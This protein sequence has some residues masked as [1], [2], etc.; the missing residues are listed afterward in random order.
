MPREGFSSQLYKAQSLKHSCHMQRTPAAAVTL[1]KPS[2]INAID[3]SLQFLAEYS[4]K[5]GMTG[6]KI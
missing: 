5:G 4:E 1:Q 6:D 2:N 3:A